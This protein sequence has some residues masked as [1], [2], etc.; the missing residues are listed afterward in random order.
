EKDPLAPDLQADVASV[1]V[2]PIKLPEIKKEPPDVPEQD[3]E[4]VQRQ[5]NNGDSMAEA[6][7]PP[8]FDEDDMSQS[9]GR[10][11]RSQSTQS[12]RGQSVDGTETEL[13]KIQGEAAKTACNKITDTGEASS[14]RNSS[15]FPNTSCPFCERSFTSRKMLEQHVNVHMGEKPFV[16]TV[17]GTAFSWCS[18]LRRH[19][20]NVHK[21]HKKSKKQKTTTG[22]HSS[23]ARLEPVEDDGTKM[24][25]TTTPASASAKSSVEEKTSVATSSEISKSSQIPTYTQKERND[26]EE[27]PPLSTKRSS[28]DDSTS[29][30]ARLRLQ[31]CH[32]C[33]RKFSSE[34]YL[35]QHMNSHSGEKPYECTQCGVTFGW[36]SSLLRHKRK[37]HRGKQSPAKNNPVVSMQT[38]TKISMVKTCPDTEV[39]KSFI[40]QTEKMDAGIPHQTSLISDGNNQGSKRLI[41]DHLRRH[42]ASGHHQCNLCGRKFSSRWHLDRHVNSHSVL[43][44]FRC[45]LCEKSF[46]WERNLKAHLCIHMKESELQSAEKKTQD[47]TRMQQEPSSMSGAKANENKYA[48]SEPSLD[49]EQVVCNESLCTMQCHVCSKRFTVLG[50]LKRHMLKHTGIKPFSCVVCG[51]KFSRKDYLQLHCKLHYKN[52]NLKQRKQNMPPGKKYGNKKN[53]SGSLDERDLTTKKVPEKSMV[54]KVQDEMTGTKTEIPQ[55]LMTKNNLVETNGLAASSSSQVTKEQYQCIMC[56]KQTNSKAAMLAHMQ[57]HMGGSNTLCSICGK[58]VNNLPQHMLQHTGEKLFKCSVCEKRFSR[59]DHLLKHELRCAQKLV[60]IEEHDIQVVKK[61]QAERRKSQRQCPVCKKMLNSSYLKEHLRIHSGIKPFQC[62]FCSRTFRFKSGYLNHLKFHKKMKQDSLK[63][64]VTTEETLKKSPKKEIENDN[65]TKKQN[66]E[67]YECSMC[68]THL[69]SKAA[70]LCHVLRHEGKGNTCNIC[71]KKLTSSK[72][73]LSHMRTHT[74]EK[75][76]ECEVCKKKFTWKESWQIHTKTHIERNNLIDEK[77]QSEHPQKRCVEDTSSENLKLIGTTSG[78]NLKQSK[79]GSSF[80]RQMV[81]VSKVMK[82]HQNINRKKFHCKVCNQIISSRIN[83]FIHMQ[84]HSKEEMFSCTICLKIFT[85]R[86]TLKIHMISHTHISNKKFDKEADNINAEKQQGKVHTQIDKS[87]TCP[88]EPTRS[89]KISTND[90]ETDE[91]FLVTHFSDHRKVSSSDRVDEGKLLDKNDSKV[92]RGVV[93]VDTN[94]SI[95]Q[96]N[97]VRLDQDS[98]RERLPSQAQETVGS[99]ASTSQSF[100]RRAETIQPEVKSYQG[101]STKGADAKNK[102]LACEL[103]GKVFSGQPKLLRHLMNQSCSQQFECNICHK[104]YSSKGRLNRHMLQHSDLS[105]CDGDIARPPLQSLQEPEVII[106]DSRSPSPE[107]INESVSSDKQRFDKCGED[108]HSMIVSGVKEKCNNENTL[109]NFV[110]PDKTPIESLTDTAQPT[111]TSSRDVCIASNSSAYRKPSEDMVT[112]GEKEDSVVLPRKTIQPEIADVDVSEVNKHFECDHCELTFDTQRAL[113]KHSHAPVTNPESPLKCRFCPLTFTCETTRLNHLQIHET[114]PLGNLPKTSAGRKR[115]ETTERIGMAEGCAKKDENT[116]DGNQIPMTEVRWTEQSLE[117]CKVCSEKYDPKNLVKHMSIHTGG[118]SFQCGL[119]GRMFAK[120]TVIKSHA[121]T[122]D[123]KMTIHFLCHMCGQALTS[124][125]ALTDHVQNHIEQLPFRCRVCGKNFCDSS[126]L[127]VHVKCHSGEKPFQC[128]ICRKRFAWKINHLKHLNMHCRNKRVASTKAAEDRQVM[129]KLRATLERRFQLAKNVD[130]KVGDSSTLEEQRQT[131][132]LEGEPTDNCTSK[133]SEVRNHKE[134]NFSSLIEADKNKPMFGITEMDKTSNPVTSYTNL[135]ESTTVTRG[136][137]DDS[138]TIVRALGRTPITARTSP[139]EV[140]DNEKRKCPELSDKARIKETLGMSRL[141]VEIKAIGD[142]PKPR[143]KQKQRP[144]ADIVITGVPVSE[145]VLEGA[146]GGCGETSQ[147]QKNSS[148]SER[149]VSKALARSNVEVRDPA[150]TSASTLLKNFAKSDPLSKHLI[151]ESEMPICLEPKKPSGN[152]SAKTNIHNIGPQ[153]SSGA[154]AQNKEVHDVAQ[155]I[156]ENHKRNVRS[157]EAPTRGRNFPDELEM[158]KRKSVP[159]LSSNR[160]VVNCRDTVIRE[161]AISKKVQEKEVEILRETVGDRSFSLTPPVNLGGRSTVSHIETEF[162]GKQ[163]TR[164]EI[165]EAT[166]PRFSENDARTICWQ[167]AHV[168]ITREPLSV[169]SCGEVLEGR[170]GGSSTPPENQR[171]VVQ[172]VES[173]AIGRTATKNIEIVDIES[174]D[175]ES[176]RSNVNPQRSITDQRV[177]GR[178]CGQSE[179]T[180]DKIVK[181]MEE[182]G[183]WASF[184]LS[185]FDGGARWPAPGGRRPVAGARCRWPAPRWPRLGGRRPVL[186]AGGRRPGAGGPVAALGRRAR[187]DGR[188]ARLARRRGPPG[189][190]F[191]GRRSV[192]G[193]RVRP[194]AS[195]PGARW[196]ALR[197][198]A[199]AGLAGA[200]WPGLRG[201]RSWP[202]LGV[203]GRARCAARVSAWPAWAARCRRPVRVIAVRRWCPRSVCRR[204]CPALGGRR[205]VAGARWPGAPGGRRSVGRRFGGRRS[206][207]GSVAGRSVAGGSVAGAR[208]PALGG[209]RSVCAGRFGVPGASGGRRLGG[210][211]SCPALAAPYNA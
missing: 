172:P 108:L 17:C 25:T 122:H 20:N 38:G 158:H 55:Q 140:G 45:S 43:K 75:P 146:R 97:P 44:P 151:S 203:A 48:R 101:N 58:K 82:K 89:S 49:S 125:K 141:D 99:N 80:H 88:K 136:L 56:S 40:P 98:K 180:C 206:W 111:A 8:P 104:N 67:N 29:Q 69:S 114:I 119:C 171:H 28:N 14:R 201:R 169:R 144:V 139:F 189:P 153:V 165:T 9:S 110:S 30:G 90:C 155:N 41:L 177:Q 187:G 161:G 115:P 102:T 178:G 105:N 194:G 197:W 95:M 13:E 160:P 175:D 109:T 91:S 93:L 142:I 143:D 33:G 147:R 24:T 204:S 137:T 199:S 19:V 21:K 211:R 128:K 47:R 166:N 124:P 120:E 4:V 2:M 192:A 186:F 3:A 34:S 191:G 37:A 208:W 23:T 112:S 168:T 200:R 131:Q 12:G 7:A 6:V 133:S 210:R 16:C 35:K 148:A 123:E 57:M 22:T 68:G 96:G 130:E 86:E 205:S 54:Q 184:F 195:W 170:T 183:T 121:K 26:I 117:Q 113:L 76:F 87:L 182:T 132:F 207:A 157:P 190:R 164:G 202:A 36:E 74:G 50:S 92:H 62:R 73:L 65:I 64:K 134:N 173:Q 70:L 94:Q 46:I 107:N 176:P 42:T 126:E 103:C 154:V 32:V 31:A 106:I 163:I 174:E 118:I 78:G 66:L 149:S 150:Q 83:F 53:T 71:D 84:S 135:P 127:Q 85:R 181:Q 156:L 39:V 10:I 15:T 116:R 51:K 193:A 129:S 77:G 5:E 209:R 138:P 159:K 196:P 188:R 27:Q 63:D 167:P 152:T 179:E 79:K 100:D 81:S 52:T 185:R 61:S 145:R 59:K 162:A 11:T 72:H 1:E 198:P 18:N 60:N